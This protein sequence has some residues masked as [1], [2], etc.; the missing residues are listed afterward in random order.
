MKLFYENFILFLIYSEKKIIDIDKPL[1]PGAF[2][3]TTK[4]KQFTE[5]DYI[6]PE[7]PPFSWLIRKTKVN[8]KMKINKNKLQTYFICILCIYVNIFVS[9]NLSSQ[10]IKLSI[11]QLIIIHIE[12]CYYL[13]LL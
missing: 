9:I 5:E 3:D 13:L 12:F 7:T 8:W 11:S 1:R 6:L 2:V 10:S 4:L